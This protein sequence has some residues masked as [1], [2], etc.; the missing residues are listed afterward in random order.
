MGGVFVSNIRSIDW[1]GCNLHIP[2]AGWHGQFHNHGREFADGSLNLRPFADW[3]IIG[4]NVGGERSNTARDRPDMQVMHAA[5]ALHSR[6]SDSIAS[7]SHQW[8]WLPQNIDRLAAGC[9]RHSQRINSPIKMLTNG[10]SQFRPV[11]RMTIPAATAPWLKG[12][13]PLGAHRRWQV[14]IMIAATPEPARP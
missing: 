13:P 6:M 7:T 1:P 8:G 11:K 3:N 14:Q 12:H 9:P 5:Y 2:V 10:S 4:Q